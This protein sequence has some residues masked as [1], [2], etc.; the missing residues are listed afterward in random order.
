MASSLF[1]SPQQRTAVQP[2]KNKGSFLKQIADFKRLLG[3][4]NPQEV[5]ESLRRSGR[6]TDRQFEELKEEA[7][8]IMA[9]L[10]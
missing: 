3:S 10:R 7:E 9:I 2:Q 6:M 5:I 4:R 1:G 8:S